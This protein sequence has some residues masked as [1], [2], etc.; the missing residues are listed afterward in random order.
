MAKTN[1]VPPLN[2]WNRSDGGDTTDLTD[3]FQASEDG[4]SCSY[5]VT[6]ENSYLYRNIVTD[7]IKGHTLKLSVQSFTASDNL[8]W[9]HIRLYNA[10]ISTYTPMDYY[11]NEVLFP[12]EIEINVPGDCG[13]IQIRFR[14][15]Y[16]SDGIDPPS[17]M[18]ISGV[19][20]YDTYT[21]S[22][23]ALNF[24]KVLE[25][26]LPE[27]VTPGTE[28]VYYTTDGST[29]KQFISTKEGMLIQ[30][31]GSSAGS[32]EADKKYK[33]A[34][35][36]LHINERLEDVKTL[37]RKGHCIIFL[38]ATDIHV[39]IEDGDVGR[40]NQVRDLIMVCDQFPVDYICCCGDIMSYCQEWNEMYEPRI[41][42]VKNIFR[43]AR[44]PWFATRGNHDYNDDDYNPGN[45]ANIIEF[46]KDSADHLFVTND[47]WNRSITSQ[48]NPPSHIKVVFDESNPLCGYFYVDDYIK[49]HRMIFTDSEETHEDEFGRPYF[50]NGEPNCYISGIETVHQVTWMVDKA[51]DMTGKT[52][53]VVSFY[54]HTAPYTDRGETDP[55]EFHGYGSN[56]PQIRA[57]IKAFQD[58]T[59]L[60][61]N[62]SA[63]DTATHEWRSIPVIKD[64]SQQ[65]AIKVIGWFAGHVHDDCYKKVDG[66]NVFVST[67][68]CAEQRKSWSQDPNGTKLPPER[69]NADLAM[70]M[71]MFIVNKDTRTVNVI[72]FGSK[73]DNTIKTSSDYEFEF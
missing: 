5:S 20:L 45:N 40:Y 16:D 1:L 69:N 65:G 25:E 70:S 60:N 28:H 64:F 17:A 19:E 73:R 32:D 33:N 23:T 53:W 38:V 66:L 56:N 36:Q 44:S 49:K 24:H 59:S 27:S 34:Y 2:Q 46:D 8:G 7:S 68:T 52:D 43:Q 62:Y 6:H 30:V 63:L 22:L 15:V 12:L 26:N 13:R 67:C 47:V 18:N 48:F 37:L 41:E 58:G 71:N 31:G 54:S 51:L 35:T 9:L 3:S 55:L 72:K 42:K 10:D 4:M 39:R 21:E 14:H 11:T 57:I 50:E 61:I 29:V